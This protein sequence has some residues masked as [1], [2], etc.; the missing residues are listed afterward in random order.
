MKEQNRVREG[1]GGAIIN[2]SSVN[3]ITA[4][5]SIAGYNSSKGGVDNLTRCR[6]RFGCWKWPH[7]PRQHGSCRIL[8][9]MYLEMLIY[10]LN[11]SMSLALAPHG[12]R[13]N[14]I[15]PGSIMT[16]VLAAVAND[17]NGMRRILSRTP[18]MRIEVVNTLGVC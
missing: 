16:D 3:G 1:R 9:C 15:G 18:M 12:V 11:R 5:P 2:M 4:I 13:V 10:L 8:T 14:A 7:R 6:L 17:E